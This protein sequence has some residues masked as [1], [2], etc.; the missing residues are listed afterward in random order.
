MLTIL[1][2][3]V[4]GMKSGNSYRKRLGYT[5]AGGFT[6]IASGSNL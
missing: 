6:M 2:E 5:S 3:S 1:L 4:W